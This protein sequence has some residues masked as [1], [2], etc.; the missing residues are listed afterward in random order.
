[1]KRILWATVLLAV[2]LAG[3]SGVWMNAEYSRLLDETAALSA[4]TARRA[5]AGLLDPNE[6]AAALRA[7]ADVWQK[8]RDARDARAPGE[9]R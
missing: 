7:Q 2:V 9:S 3:C 5:E 8:F 6:A 1:M 4:E